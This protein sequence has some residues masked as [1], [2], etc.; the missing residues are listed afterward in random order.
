MK[1][2][3]VALILSAAMVFSACGT[4][5][6]AKTD[7]GATNQEEEISAGTEIENDI[8]GGSPWICSMIKENIASA[9]HPSEKDDFYLA[10]NQDY[11]MTMEI[12]EGYS[13]YGSMYEVEDI[14]K[15]KAMKLLEDDS[16]K[17]HEAELCQEMYNAF[18]DWDARN[19]IGLAP[20]EETFADL[21]NVESIDELNEMILDDNRSRWI[22]TLFIVDNEVNLVDSKNY[23]TYITNYGFFLGD[24]AEYDK[25]TDSGKIR[26]KASENQVVK[27]LT[28]MGYTET[29]A[30]KMF[31]ETL[32]F[33]KKIAEVSMTNLEKSS[34]D[35]YEKMLN[36]YKP[37]D[38]K[39]LA[40]NFP[41]KE[42]IEHCGYGKAKQFIVMEPDVLKRISDLYVDENLDQIK[43][44]LKVN[45]VSDNAQFLDKES[46][47]ASIEEKNT[48][49][50]VSGK[51][52]YRE[53][54]FD[55]VMSIMSGALDQAYIAKYDM[56]EKKENVTKICNDVKEIY[57]KM[58][59]TEDWLSEETRNYAISKIDNMDVN[60]ISSGQYPD[61]SSMDFNG[62]SYIEII[63]EI[64]DFIKEENAVKTN[65]P[66]RKGVW[67]ESTLMA[68]AF[69]MPTENSINIFAGILEEPFYSDDMSIEEMYGGIGS[70]IGH[71][72][73]H[74]FDTNGAQF[75]KEGN[76]NN[77][78]TD[79]D[80]KA[81][82]DRAK[83]QI[84]YYNTI[85][86]FGDTKANGEL[87]QTEVIADMAG[88]KAMLTLAKEQ[89][90]F[91]YDKFFKAYANIWASIQSYE[92]VL[93][94]ASQDE[95]PLNYL[96]T[97]ATVQQY[98]EFYET[99]DVKEGDGM[100]LAPEERVSIW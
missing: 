84:D 93:N 82:K 87:V 62:L 8:T 7:E 15:K 37:E 79:E 64:N 42:F 100:Y 13:G 99:Y 43:T 73:S 94:Q 31:A 53:Y 74:A 4:T 68:N 80:Y 60:V 78:W 95:H 65:Q 12:P 27:M 39:G 26:K 52:D 66:T 91:D 46:F 19:K 55:T 89:E 38:I 69:Y 61:Y 70:V 10:T 97:N 47:D 63:N 59:S 58:L 30:K 44:Y 33:E 2:K 48:I 56:T 72:I 25:L 28:R 3:I 24:A 23:V 96:R 83:K 21:D 45:S 49:Y 11:L 77:W 22:K 85:T 1:R 67:D 9:E 88:V 41:L 40:P 34:P 90:N 98:E 92:D 75:D 6:P 86:V 71:E 36:F 50:G 54:A 29:E 20:L 51:M 14:T 57:K 32:E 17:G 81:F 35:A 16:V 18:L 5:A 76:Y